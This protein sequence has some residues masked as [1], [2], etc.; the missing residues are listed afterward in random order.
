MCGLKF[1]LLAC[2]WP[3][4]AHKVH[5]VFHLHPR[6]ARSAGAR[7][8]L[9]LLLCCNQK[10]T[11]VLRFAAEQFAENCYGPFWAMVLQN[12]L[13]RVH[14]RQG[15]AGSSWASGLVLRSL[16]PTPACVWDQDCEAKNAEYSSHPHAQ[17][18]HVSRFRL[19]ASAP[20]PPHLRRRGPAKE[21]SR[22][23]HELCERGTFRSLS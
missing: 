5:A 6:C 16:L 20:G 19:C 17:P 14:G 2:P 8:H 7:V 10:L 3:K 15:A 22:R 12:Q 4:C 13:R 1:G 23:M 21:L 11:D 18:L 9:Q